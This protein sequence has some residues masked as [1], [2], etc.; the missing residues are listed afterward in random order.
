MADINA[1]TFT[2]RLTADAEYKVLQSG[3][4]LLVMNVAVNTGYGEYAK[5]TFL[6]VQQWGERGAKM[7]QYCKKGQ[8]VGG[9]G[10]LTTNTWQTNMG[11]SRTDLVVTVMAIQLLGSKKDNETPSAP[12]GAVSAVKKAGEPQ[13]NPPEYT[14]EDGEE[15][16]F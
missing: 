4:G 8:L 10:E 16:P 1:M 13:E 12:A 15:I 14:I 6:K 7:A 11:E 3:K 9:T 5:T 2:G